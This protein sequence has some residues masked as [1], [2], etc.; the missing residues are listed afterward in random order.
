M[1]IELN[2]SQECATAWMRAKHKRHW[3]ALV[4]AEAVGWGDCFPLFCTCEV[5]S[6]I[7]WPVLARRQEK[8]LINRRDV[9]GW[10]L[11]WSGSRGTKCTRK[12]WRSWV[13]SALRRE[14]CIV[15][16][17]RERAWSPNCHLILRTPSV[18]SLYPCLEKA[19][20]T[21]VQLRGSEIAEKE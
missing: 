6:G 15:G 9:S 20:T 7:M 3:A 12:D 10:P 1:D 8:K 2:V 11:M 21:V 14:G 5:T 18:A 4:T 17:N 16:A 13:Y 19:H